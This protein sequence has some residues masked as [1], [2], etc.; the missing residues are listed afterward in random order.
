MGCVSLPLLQSYLK[1]V[2]L[3]TAVEAGLG[4]HVGAGPSGETRLAAEDLGRVVRSVH[5]PSS[6][7]LLPAVGTENFRS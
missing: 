4:L 7:Q 5:R 3:L 2:N 6:L 1:P